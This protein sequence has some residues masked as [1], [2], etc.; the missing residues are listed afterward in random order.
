MYK[1]LYDFIDTDGVAYYKGDSYPLFSFLINQEHINYLLSNENKA[2]KALI[3]KIEDKETEEG[4]NEEGLEEK[5]GEETEKKEDSN[6]KTNSKKEVNT[7][8]R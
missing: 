3:E 2:G 4:V 1:V 5:L 7:D 6:N 8:E